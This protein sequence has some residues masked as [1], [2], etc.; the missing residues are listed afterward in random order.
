MIDLISWQLLRARLLPE[1]YKACQ[2]LPESY[3]KKMFSQ[4]MDLHYFYNTFSTIA[5]L[6]MNEVTSGDEYIVT[7]FIENTGETSEYANVCYDLFDE[8]S[9]KTPQ[10]IVGDRIWDTKIAQLSKRSDFSELLYLKTQKASWVLRNSRG[11]C[12]LPFDRTGPV[13]VDY[14]LTL[15]EPCFA[16]LRFHQKTI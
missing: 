9:F 12:L 2:E 4:E 5:S 8:G 11:A 7:H 3:L 16:L 15:L 1:D 13:N 10:R 14:L 6:H